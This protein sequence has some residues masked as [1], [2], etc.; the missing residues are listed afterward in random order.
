MVQLHCPR[1]H[2]VAK[3]KGHMLDHLK[4]QKTCPATY[5]DISVDE[6]L[7]TLTAPKEFQCDKCDKSFSYISSLQ[8]HMK[9]HTSVSTTS[10]SETHTHSHNTVSH[11]DNNHHNTT[12]DSNHHN[13]TND[14]NHHNTNN[15]T[16]NTV[17]SN[18]VTR[19]EIHYEAPVINI[20]I[21]G[22]E[23]IEYIKEHP[24]FLTDCLQTITRDGMV[25]L[26]N[27]IHFNEQHPENQNVKF[28]SSHHPRELRVFTKE[29]DEHEPSWKSRDATEILNKMI[30]GETKVL[31]EHKDHLFTLI[32]EP[33]SEDI[34]TH[35]LRTE[36][37]SDIRSHKKGK[38]APIR[39]RMF[40]EI[41]RQ[42][43]KEICGEEEQQS[44][45]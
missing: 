33:K 29:T 2:Y 3:Q 20:N 15:T 44:S 19:N 25:K 24:E 32:R 23:Q 6:I 42:G 36:R 43:R 12:N 27:E 5:Q 41:R 35:H 17:N 9:C 4:K 14:S 30:E 1:C 11:S 21:F 18:N 7:E 26:M 34:D 40:Q 13:T 45:T 8:R 28:K 38:Y 16:N 31:I 22:Q 37:L 10:V 39:D